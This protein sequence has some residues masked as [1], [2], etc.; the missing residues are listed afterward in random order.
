[1]INDVRLTKKLFKRAFRV[2]YVLGGK[3]YLK[4]WLNV[5]QIATETKPVENDCTCI[6]KHHTKNCTSWPRALWCIRRLCL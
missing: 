3:N 6:K 4:K 5:K 1:L 2:G